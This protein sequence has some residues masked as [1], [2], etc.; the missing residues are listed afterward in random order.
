MGQLMR[1]SKTGPDGNIDKVVSLSDWARAEAYYWRTML[2]FCSRRMLLPDPA[3]RL[4]EWSL[5]AYPDAAGG[6]LRM[7]GLG[8][9][10]VLGPNWWAYLPWGHAINSGKVYRDGQKLS[11]K[12]SAWELV[13][14]LLVLTAGVDLVR[15]RS[16]IIPVDN[17]GS[18]A[19]YRKGWCTSCMLCTTLALAV[20]EISAAINCKLEIT[21]IK[22]CSNDQAEAADAV[23]KADWARFRRLMPRANMEPARIP[24]TLVRWIQDPVED[25]KLGE[26]ILKE[27][28]FGRNPFGHHDNFV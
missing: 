3:Y 20:S 21:K 2:P 9:G 23:S 15:N 14:P 4:P 8:A 5:T 18:G 10:A 28:G 25:R 16:L 26:R 12:M 17:Y 27:M 1:S 22:R 13:G 11:N 19:I 6:S 7:K 24:V